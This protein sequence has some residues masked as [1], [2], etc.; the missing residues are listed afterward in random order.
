MI[1]SNSKKFIFFHIPKSGGT[2][3]CYNLCRYSENLDLFP[4]LNDILVC[5]DEMYPHINPKILDSLINDRLKNIPKH[6]ITD[7]CIKYPDQIHWM[8]VFH[9]GFDLH[10]LCRN[11]F[12]ANMILSKMDNTIFD[13][14]FKFAFVRNPWDYVLSL[15]KNK[16]V[17]PH[18]PPRVGMPYEISSEDFNRFICNINEFPLLLNTFFKPLRCQR[19]FIARPSGKIIVDRICRYEN[20]NSELEFLSNRLDVDL[21]SNVKLNTTTKDPLDYTEFYNDQSM[22]FVQNVFKSDIEYFGYKFGG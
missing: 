3:L 22:R 11:D 16:V 20:Y 18:A 6:Y 5:L 1:I 10:P 14:Y 7:Y 19:N 9:Y 13:D 4:S 17:R 21:N 15:Y 12:A 8:N 2:S